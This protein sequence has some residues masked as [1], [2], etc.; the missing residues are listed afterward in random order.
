MGL[1]IHSTN[2]YHAATLHQVYTAS[3]HF[4]HG[5]YILVGEMVKRCIL[6]GGAV[7]ETQAERTAVVYLC[8]SIIFF[9]YFQSQVQFNVIIESSML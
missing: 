3:R 9:E 4:P 2:I 8:L 5:A 7:G 1:F 6:G